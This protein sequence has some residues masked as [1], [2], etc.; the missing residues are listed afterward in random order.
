MRKI[1]IGTILFISSQ[2]SFGQTQ[3]EMNKSAMDEYNSADKKLHT[4]YSQILKDYKA[5][6]VFISNIKKAQHSWIQFRDDEMNMMYPERKLGYYGTIHPLCW[7]NYKKEL[8]EERIKKL[9]Q[10][11]DGSDDDSCSSTIKSK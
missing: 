10:W 3:A 11:L 8:T 6:T 4:I 2:F 5:D 7:Y 1:V 9:K